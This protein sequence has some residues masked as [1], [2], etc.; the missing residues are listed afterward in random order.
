MKTKLLKIVALITFVTLILISAVSCS[1]KEFEGISLTDVTVVYSQSGH[2][3]TIVGEDKYPNATFTL[4]EDKINVGVYTQVLT[5]TQEG[6]KPF[7]ATATLTINKAIPENLLPTY[8]GSYSFVENTISVIR[9]GN[10]IIIT[11]FTNFE[12]QPYA[13]VEYYQNQTNLESAPIEAGTYNIKLSVPEVD[14]YYALEKKL[15]SCK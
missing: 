14:N 6:Y 4:S 8:N 7:E 1:E 10:P 11:P 15:H 13:T 2:N 9:T 3:V 5:V 12:Q